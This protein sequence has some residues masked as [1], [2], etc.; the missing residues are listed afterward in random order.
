MNRNKI[1]INED[2]DFTM[3]AKADEFFAGSYFIGIDMDENSFQTAQSLISRLSIPP[4]FWYTSFSH[5]QT[6]KD[7]GEFMGVRLRLIYIFDEMITDKYFF[8]Y[9]SWT[10][11]KKIECDIEESISDTCGMM[12]AQYFNG[13][14]SVD[15]NLV[16]E[17][18]L[19]NNIYSLSD[20]NISDDGYFEFL[21]SGCQ[22]R[23]I[24]KEKKESILNE[25]RNFS[26]RSFSSHSSIIQISPS[27]IISGW[28]ENERLTISDSESAFDEELLRDSRLLQWDEFYK[29]YKHKYPYVYRVE[30]DEWLSI[31]GIKYQLCDKNYLELIWIPQ[32]IADGH[33]R[34]H[35]LFHRAWL[36]RVIMPSITPSALLFNLLVDRE[37]FFDNTDGVLSLGLLKDKVK[38]SFMFGI[39]EL[40]RRYSAVYESTKDACKN[41]QFIIH[42]NSKNVNPM[43]IKKELKWKMIDAVY[44]HSKTFCDN[45]QILNDSDFP[46]DDNTLYRYCSERGIKILTSRTQK[47]ERFK[48]LHLPGMSIR[49]EQRY[50]KNLGLD[51]STS[52]LSGYIKKLQNE[53]KDT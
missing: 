41:K 12:C 10:L 13:T 50:L 40:I 20:I 49:E 9:C 28:E 42:R 18:G 16:V 46:I 23:I 33:H 29:I 45:L 53:P 51:L 48:E 43:S 17:F 31:G 30:K 39:D 25:I 15:A 38:E 37:Y 22:Y 44:D 19:S 32:R 8:R 52:T 21:L 35:T 26:N 11:H 7:T 6:D 4:T 14:N 24:D 36:R 5:M 3:S 47:Y 1:F 27:Q 2:G 34:R